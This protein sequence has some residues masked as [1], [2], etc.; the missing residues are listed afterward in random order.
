MVERFFRDLTCDRL[1]R[2]VFCSVQ[3]LTSAIEEYIALHNA[4]PKPL[5]WTA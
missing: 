3:Q 5:I 1:K 4:N 2:G